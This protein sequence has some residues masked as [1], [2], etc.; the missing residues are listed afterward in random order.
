MRKLLFT[1]GLLGLVA[2]AGYET[3][4]LASA[5]QTCT[6]TCTSGSPITCIVAS[7]T[8]STSSNSVTCCGST[9]GCSAINSYDACFQECQVAFDGCLSRCP[10]HINCLGKCQYYEGICIA[11][12]CGTR[13]VTTFSC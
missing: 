1:V 13:P 2:S 9:H 3:T 5:S 11:T 12:N 4:P 6:V 8:C 7:G 10:P